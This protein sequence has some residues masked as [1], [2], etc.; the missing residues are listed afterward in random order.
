M[1]D[2]PAVVQPSD[3]WNPTSLCVAASIAALTLDPSKLPLSP[4]QAV[5][6]AR[7][8][9]QLADAMGLVTAKKPRR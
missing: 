8:V 9:R 7:L 5:A 6:H 1:A 3:Q 2:S 4:D